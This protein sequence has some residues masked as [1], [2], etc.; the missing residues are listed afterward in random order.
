MGEEGGTVGA[1]SLQQAHLLFNSRSRSSPSQAGSCL[2]RASNLLKSVYTQNQQLAK[3]LKQWT[4]C[5]FQG[6]WQNIAGHCRACVV[7][8]PKKYDPDVNC[9]S[10]QEQIGLVYH[11]GNC[12]SNLLYWQVICEGGIGEDGLQSRA[13]VTFKVQHPVGSARMQFL[14][15]SDA[16]LP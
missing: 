7:V 13:I 4:L 16:I 11:S 10:C 5:Q 1:F 15:S 9:C 3:Y 2:L 14:L 12:C 6:F 8:A